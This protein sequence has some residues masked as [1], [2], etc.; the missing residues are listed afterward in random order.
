[1][2]LIP[3]PFRMTSTTQNEEDS[4]LIGSNP[5]DRIFD[6]LWLDLD[7]MI[8]EFAPQSLNLSQ[9]S[10]SV[11]PCCDCG[12]T[13]QSGT[14][15][16]T[17]L[18]CRAQPARLVGSHWFARI[19]G[20]IEADGPVAWDQLGDFS[21]FIFNKEDPVIP[22]IQPLYG[23]LT[24]PGINTAFQNVF[25]S[26]YHLTRLE[27]GIIVENQ[28]F[29]SPAMFNESILTVDLPRHG[30]LSDLLRKTNT[31]PMAADELRVSTS[32]STL[33]KEWADTV[34]LFNTTDRV[35]VINYLRSV[36]RL[37]PLGSAITSVFVSTF[38]MVSVLWTVF[39][40]IAGVIAARAETASTHTQFI[41]STLNDRIEN[42]TVAIDTHGVD[43]AHMKCSFARMQLALKKRGLLEEDDEEDEED[44]LESSITHTKGEDEKHT[45]LVHRLKQPDSYSAV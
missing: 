31:W 38:A 37:K 33:M 40:L 16:P 3:T 1:M 17:E 8:S 12:A 6:G 36:P 10:A 23:F 20:S 24:L 15:L 34:H 28:I 42:H 22:P 30:L 9:L 35:P 19:D 18:P 29:N 43:I 14:S 2:C 26:L 13:L 41:P 32:N 4:D 11:V 21:M 44:S 39:S 5:F 27:L 45:L 7:F 25:Q